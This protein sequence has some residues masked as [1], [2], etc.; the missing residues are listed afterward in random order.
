VAADFDDNGFQ[1]LYVANDSDANI[2]WMNDHGHFTDEGLL[3]GAAF[4]EHGVPQA[5][6]GIAIGDYNEDGTLDL[7]DTNLG[8]E[9]NTL[10]E[11]RGKGMFEDVTA[12]RG[13]G[14]S[15]YIF[16][17]FGTGWY[18]ADNDGDL[19]LFIVNGEV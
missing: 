7:F 12:S 19:D 13:L 5:G 2:L 6:M 11:G 9:T 18:D 16:T 4:N 8:N 14:L 1:D 17:G 15:S 10:W 3:R